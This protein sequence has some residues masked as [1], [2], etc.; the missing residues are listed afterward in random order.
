MF[1]CCSDF[2][3]DVI[4]ELLEVADAMADGSYWRDD[5]REETQHEVFDPANADWG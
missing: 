4:D 1:R 2:M 5:F 3:L